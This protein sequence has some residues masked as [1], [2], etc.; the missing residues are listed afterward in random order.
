MNTTP[1]TL[2]ASLGS[3]QTPLAH[4]TTTFSPLINNLTAI[5]AEPQ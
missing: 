2:H 4:F 3:C 5:T 1:H